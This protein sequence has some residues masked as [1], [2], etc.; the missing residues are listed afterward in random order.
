MRPFTLLSG[1]SRNGDDALENMV[2]CENKEE[3]KIVKAKGLSYIIWK[4]TDK[5]LAKHLFLRVLEAKYPGIK[6]KEVLG[7]KKAKSVVAFVEGHKEVEMQRSTVKYESD[8]HACIATGERII[9]A[10]NEVEIDP[11]RQVDLAEYAADETAKVNIDKLDE[12]DLL[13]SFLGDVYSC[14]K[15]NL[16]QSAW[17]EGWTKKLHAPM[18]NY[19]MCGGEGDNLIILDVSHSIPEGIANTMITMIDT[20]RSKVDA[21]L[22]VTGGV[23]LWFGKDED[24]PSPEKLRA[25]VPRSNESRDFNEILSK[26]VSLHD[27]DNVIA[28]GD[29][30][31]PRYYHE[32]KKALKNI[33]VGKFW[34]YHTRQFWY[35]RNDQ[36]CGY[37]KWQEYVSS[38]KQPPS[39]DTSW[40]E[41]MNKEIR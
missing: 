8:G 21:D 36:N 39:Y 25:M 1:L 2:I 12:L 14:V 22:I 31:T 35:V 6:W 19:R 38:V 30:D 15:R 26:R 16:L 40:C 23:S 11:Y 24:L 13:P 32:T 9:D 37:A 33:S 17:E 5:D 28:F 27:W 20:M 10:D 7:I 34:H 3:A 4:G 41:I 29:C 18:G